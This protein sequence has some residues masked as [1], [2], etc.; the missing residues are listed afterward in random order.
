MRL[1][2]PRLARRRAPTACRR[3][4]G[5]AAPAPRSGTTGDPG[6]RRTAAPPR[7][8]RRPRASTGAPGPTPAPRRAGRAA[9]CR[10]PATPATTARAGASYPSSVGAW[11]VRR[12]RGRQF[13]MSLHRRI[14]LGAPRAMPSRGHAPRPPRSRHHAFS[15]GALRRCRGA[16]SAPAARSSASRAAKR[17][18]TIRSA[19]ASSL[20]SCH[21]GTAITNMPAARPAV[22]PARESSSTAQEEGVTRSASAARRKMSG[23][24]LGEA[25]DSPETTAANRPRSAKR[26][27][28]ASISLAGDD[29]ATADGSPA[30][31]AA[32]SSSR[33]PGFNES[34]PTRAPKASMIALVSSATSTG[35]PKSPLI[36]RSVC[37]KP[38]P[39]AACAW[40]FVHAPPRAAANARSTSYQS[41]SESTIRPSMSSTSACGENFPSCFESG[42]IAAR[43]RNPFVRK[44]LAWGRTGRVA[45]SCAPSGRA[46]E[47][48]V[49]ARWPWLRGGSR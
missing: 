16:G 46:K 13:I 20:E 12:S 28:T 47:I 1:L 8:A 35:N 5:R 36:V 43:E 10:S 6:A 42:V 9:A 27:S 33:Q 29:D 25:T 30:A 7:R 32:S 44:T 3:S 40:A 19:T 22:A 15:V 48:E 45:M 49:C 34:S 4:C 18:G 21:S 23:A 31:P 24:G 37:A 2:Q 11:C 17:S 41:G 38:R 26:P 14:A 39:M